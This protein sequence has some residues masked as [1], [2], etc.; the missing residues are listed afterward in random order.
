MVRLSLARPHADKGE[1]PSSGL[2][3]RW[4][5]TGDPLA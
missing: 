2:L 5:V 3:H 4:Q 1:Q